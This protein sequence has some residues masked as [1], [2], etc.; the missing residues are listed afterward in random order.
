[1]TTVI[2]FSEIKEGH[3]VV[4]DDSVIVATSDAYMTKTDNGK[5]W[6]F[7]SGDDYYYISDFDGAVYVKIIVDSDEIKW[8]G[9]FH[10][11]KFWR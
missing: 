8:R 4:F 1:M 3:K 6:N 11:I 10:Y 2:H 9:W 7:E 5:E